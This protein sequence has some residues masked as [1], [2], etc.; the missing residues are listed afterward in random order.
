MMASRPAAGLNLGPLQLEGPV[1]FVQVADP[2]H[3]ADLQVLAPGAS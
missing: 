1:A 3:L 2:V